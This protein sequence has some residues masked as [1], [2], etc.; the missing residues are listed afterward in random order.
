MRKGRSIKVYG[1]MMLRFWRIARMLKE[2][3]KVKWVKIK[4]MLKNLAEV[5]YFFSWKYNF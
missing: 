1:K 5:F 2:Q 4:K 3:M